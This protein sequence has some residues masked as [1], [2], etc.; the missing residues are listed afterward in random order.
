MSADPEAATRK[1]PLAPP[2]TILA[3]SNAIHHY[4]GA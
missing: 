3:Q 4:P 1:A 2:L